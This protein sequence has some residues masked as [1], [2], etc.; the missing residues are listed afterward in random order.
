[1]D[2]FISIKHWLYENKNH[3]VPI[4]PNRYVYHVSNPFYRNQIQQQGLIPKEKSEAWL[5]DTPIEGKVIFASNS[6]KNR[7][8]STYDD[9]IYR[10]D[11]SKILN[12]WFFDPNFSWKKNNPFIITFEPIPLEAIELIYSGSGS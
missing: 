7:F 6:D 11:T 12:Q 1:M 8:D 10:I 2:N 3:L 4:E 5:E 9:D